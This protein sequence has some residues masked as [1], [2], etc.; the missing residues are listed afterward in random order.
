[1]SRR[2]GTSGLAL[3]ALATTFATPA[4]GQAGDSAAAA[5]V[6]D[7][8]NQER[9]AVLTGD[10]SAL[11]RLWSPQLTVNAPTNRV[12]VGREVV[13]GIVQQGGLHYSVFDRAIE[14][15]LVTGDVAVVMGSETVRAATDTAGGAGLVQRRFTNVWKREGPTWRMIARHANVIPAR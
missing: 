10:R 1:V 4:L 7:L 3:L 2:V 6:R 15:V 13:L 8:D 14:A 9:L 12:N 11:E 5:I